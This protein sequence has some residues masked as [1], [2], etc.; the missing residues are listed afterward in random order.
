MSW[1]A[2]AQAVPVCASVSDSRLLIPDVVA[3]IA[4]E[5]ETS[6]TSETLPYVGVAVCEVPVVCVASVVAAAV[7]VKVKL[8]TPTK[9]M[10]VAGICPATLI[11]A[12][13]PTPACVTTMVGAAAVVSPTAFAM[14]AFRPAATPA[15][16]QFALP[17]AMARVAACAAASAPLSAAS[18]SRLAAEAALE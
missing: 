10:T 8:G 2:K 9:L 11:C 3:A 13:A 17:A 15:A 7:F 6:S 14:K 1:Q 16:F 4:I 12:V 18:P 5:G